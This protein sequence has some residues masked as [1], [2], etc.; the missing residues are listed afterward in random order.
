MHVCSLVFLEANTP[1]TKRSLR[2][3]DAPKQASTPKKRGDW[4]VSKVRWQA[5]TLLLMLRSG[6]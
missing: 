5:T 2:K 3:V 6:G 1:A 4:A